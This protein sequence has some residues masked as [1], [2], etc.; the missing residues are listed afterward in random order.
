MSMT[1]RSF[2]KGLIGLGL[3]VVGVN[4]ALKLAEPEKPNLFN[5][6]IGRHEG[7]TFVGADY[8]GESITMASLLR[9]KELLE[10]N[11]RRPPKYFLIDRRSA[12]ILG[13]K[14]KPGRE[15]E[16]LGQWVVIA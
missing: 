6:V 2:L 4:Q 13:L 9:A 10:L 3:G 5:G 1:R 7:F 15:F 14:A 16:L 12:K 11:S 8:G